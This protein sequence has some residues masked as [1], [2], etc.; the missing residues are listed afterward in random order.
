MLARCD[1]VRGAIR[2]AIAPTGLLFSYHPRRGF[3]DRERQ[4]AGRVEE[5][6]G[7]HSRPRQ[8]C[9]HPG[10]HSG[11]GRGRGAHAHALSV[12]RSLY[13]RAH[14]RGEVLCKACRGRGADGRR[15]GRR[16]R[17]VAPS[18]LCR[19]RH[20]PGLWRLAGICAVQRHRAA[21]ARSGG[22]AGL[23]RARRPR[24][25][26]DD[27]LCR[28]RRDRAAQAG[29]DRRGRSSLRRHRCGGRADRQDQG[30]PRGGDRRRRGQV[31]LRRRRRSAS[32]P[33][34]I[35]APPI[36]ATRSP[37]PVQP[38]STSISRMS[39][40]PCSRRCGRCSTTS[41]AFPCVA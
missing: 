20:R 21:Q 30:L 37:P 35:I 5:P 40:A 4:P 12:A 2:Y 3:D 32:T 19:R 13:A 10:G 29:R 23:D 17:R 8:F 15:H 22:G 7:R 18:E 31:P 38:A 16:D 11:A 39:A 34:S 14:E 6:P 26:G 41:R 28:P 33:A 9:A 27:G 36:F 1:W 25:A 24:H